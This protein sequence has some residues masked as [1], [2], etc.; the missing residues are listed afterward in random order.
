MGKLPNKGVVGLAFRYYDTT[1]AFLSAHLTSDGEGSD[2]FKKRNSNANHI[3][4]HM[5]LSPDDVGC[6][7]HLQ[8]HHTFLMGDLNYRMKG[9]HPDTI[10]DKLAD[11]AACE[12]KAAGHE[13]RAKRWKDLEMVSAVGEFTF[14]CC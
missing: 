13:W 14:R 2:R 9:A 4:D 1:I 7:L 12:R 3:L 11:V 8:H 5:V 10:L 6:S